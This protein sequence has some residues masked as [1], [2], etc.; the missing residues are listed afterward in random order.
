M[1]RRFSESQHTEPANQSQP[2]EEGA[3]VREGTE[4][5]GIKVNYVK[6]NAFFKKTSMNTC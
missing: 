5:C 2:I 1:Q 3:F 6:N 4:R